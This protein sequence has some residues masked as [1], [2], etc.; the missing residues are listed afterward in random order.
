MVLLAWVAFGGYSLADEFQ[1]ITVRIVN[2]A[3]SQEE[4]IIYSVRTRIP[5]DR[6]ISSMPYLAMPKGCN[7]VSQAMSRSSNRSRLSNEAWQCDST[8]HGTTL[9]MVFA[10]KNL[11][12]STII[13]I[14]HGDGDS[15]STVLAAEQPSWTVPAALSSSQVG[16]QYL[17]LGFKHLITGFDHLLFVVCLLF[18]CFGSLRLLVLT[19][20]SFTIAHSLSLGLTAFGII[21]MHTRAVEAII[22]LSIAYLASDIIRYRRHQTTNLGSEPKP[23]LSHRYPSLV[24]GAF[25]LIHGL[26]FANILSEFG[27]PKNDELIALL[28]FNI[29]I[30]IG[31]LAFIATIFIIVWILKRLFGRASTSNKNNWIVP[32]ATYS[33]G[34]IAMFWTVERVLGVF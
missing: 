2:S 5:N 20:T 29:G 1:P 10:Q 26:G 16:M 3:G 18:I 27:L 21:S 17:A 30:E 7:R 15:I 19:V 22:A 24:A 6:R 14:D 33:V 34:C 32:L 9:E 13:S 31:Q 8:L 28:S 23:P 25:G 11:A 4:S 12:I